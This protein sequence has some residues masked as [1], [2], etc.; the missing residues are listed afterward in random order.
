[1]TKNEFAIF[2]AALKT[3]YSKED[4]LLPNKQAME[5]WFE[6]LSD[7]PY[8]VAETALK[9]WV[10]TNKWSPSIAEIREAAT[11]IAIGE[12]PDWGKAWEQ[13]RF[14]MMRYGRYQTKEAFACMD[15]LTRQTVERLG[16]TALC[17]SENEAA[18]RANFRLIYEQLAERKKK[19][20]QM[21]TLLTIK[22][23]ELQH[24]PKLLSGNE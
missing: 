9:K 17:A 3:Y 10:A 22:I 12:I 19:A 6:Q 24:N 8:I 18:D 5:L 2:A 23:S 14:A 4:K 20:A 7:I 15:D 13:V 1:M 11:E 16:F 21:P